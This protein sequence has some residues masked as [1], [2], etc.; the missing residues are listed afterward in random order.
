MSQNKPI[1]PLESIE[2]RE[3]LA[4]LTRLGLAGAGLSLL[5]HCATRDTTGRYREGNNQGQDTQLSVEDERAM[6]AKVMP[7]MRKDYP[8]I[9]DPV[10]QNYLQSLGRQIALRNQLEGQPYQYNFTL[11][12]TPQV[13]AFALPAGEVMVTAPLILMA[14]S[15][16]ELAGVIGHE[17]GHIQA[18]HTAERMETAK[19]AQS[20]T[21]KYA[22]GGSVLGGLLGYG[23]GQLI[24][25]PQDQKCKNQALQNGLG[26]GVAGA[27]LVQKYGFMQNSQEDELEAD[28]IGFRT[29]FKAGYHPQHIGKFYEKLYAMEVARKKQQGAAPGVLASFQDALSTHPP[30]QQRVQQMQAMTQEVGNSSNNSKLLISSNDFEQIKKR[31]AQRYKKANS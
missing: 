24:C 7:Q 17:I 27:L 31:L 14:D 23:V 13:N 5:G 6:T 29:S 8:S 1:E 10:A 15:E 25:P 19:K 22:L 4:Y 20:S 26:L 30:T 18:R 9:N 2:R 16:A 11:V 21:W 28:R 12:E 3:V